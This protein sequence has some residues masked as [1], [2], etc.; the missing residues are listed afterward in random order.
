MMDMMK[1]LLTFPFLRLL[2]IGL[3]VVCIIVLVHKSSPVIQ[4]LG[5]NTQYTGFQ[6]IY[7]SGIKVIVW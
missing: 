2:V 6:N 5:N 3:A 7:N 4:L 1:L